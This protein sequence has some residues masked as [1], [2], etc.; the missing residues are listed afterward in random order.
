MGALDVS[1]VARSILETV[2]HAPTNAFAMA[3]AC[4]IWLVPTLVCGPAR[5]VESTLYYDATTSLDEQTADILIAISRWHLPT[6]CESELVML[7]DLLNGC[8]C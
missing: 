2:G 6:A 8:V 7:A 1:D 3:V 5:L 4:G